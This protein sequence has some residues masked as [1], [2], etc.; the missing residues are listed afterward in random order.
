[1]QIAQLHLIN[2]SIKLYI[3]ALIGQ[4]ELKILRR[5]LVVMLYCTHECMMI[6]PNHLQSSQSAESQR[7]M[8]K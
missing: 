1:M 4:T 5:L 6:K 7:K 3:K 2:L 8:A